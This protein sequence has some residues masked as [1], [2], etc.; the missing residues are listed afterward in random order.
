MAE[1]VVI[2]GAGTTGFQVARHL[3]ADNKNVVLI[4]R[5]PET[6]KYAVNH[7]DCMVINDSGNRLPA[8]REAGI[9]SADFFISVTDSDELNIV[10][11][12][13]VASE[14]GVPCKIAR[15]RNPDYANS[16]LSGH[17]LLDVDYF[18][19]PEIEAAEAISKSVEQGATSDVMTFE[20]TDLQ[21]R[22][23]LVDS[24]TLFARQSIASIKQSLDAEF[25]V[26]G[27]SRGEEFFVPRGDTVVETGDELYLVAAE[28]TLEEVF[29][30][31]GRPRVDLNRVLLIGGGRVGSFV[32]G[33]LS[34]RGYRGTGRRPRRLLDYLRRDTRRM[35]IVD[36]N[37]DNCKRL[38]EQFPDAIVINSD[39]SEEGFFEEE[40]LTGTD[41]IITT[42]DNPE[43]NILVAIY[44]KTLGIKRSIALV[45]KFNYLT[46]ASRLGVDVI[47]SPK[48]SVVN[49]ILKFIRRGK[50]KSVHSIFGGLAEVIESTLDG[51]RGFVGRE[52]R[53]VRM[54]ENSLI[55]AVTRNGSNIVPRSNYTLR[56]G[57]KL[58]MVAKTESI[59]RVEEMFN[60]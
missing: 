57:D 35:K 17:S 36:A 38:A 50:V 12:G 16:N 33:A 18:V 23:F 21:M 56:D 3:I 42:T 1:K 47:I 55:V 46:V 10:S 6:A 31:A 60:T 37:Y 32:A 29:V 22:N 2:A 7:L 51:S 30:I 26:A 9:E 54:P 45:N 11:C 19:N 15:V 20:N 52:V 24:R 59:S 53:E 4:E 27:I 8:L 5:N 58:T 13:L 43:L 40:A 34:R 28:H 49:T 14:F 39:V 41:L 25:L 48:Y 44:A